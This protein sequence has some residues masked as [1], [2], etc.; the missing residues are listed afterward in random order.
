VEGYDDDLVR[1]EA[2]G[3]AP[4]PVA[5]D[6]GYVEREGVRIHY[7]AYG[8]GLAVILLH[9]GLGQGGTG[10]IRFRRSSGVAIAQW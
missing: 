3:A 7:A 9:G 4:L 5:D 1:F 8:S 10:A 2:E 6:E